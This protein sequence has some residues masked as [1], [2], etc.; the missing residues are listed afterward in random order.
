MS[1][2]DLRRQAP[3]KH[4]SVVF[5]ETREIYS[6]SFCNGEPS[7][8]PNPANLMEW[9]E[10]QAARL[11]GLPEVST[12]DQGIAPVFQASIAAPPRE[13]LAK[14]DPSLSLANAKLR[15]YDI[16]TLYALRKEAAR[17]N[18]ELKIHT[19]ALKGRQPTRLECFKLHPL[20]RLTIL[21]FSAYFDSCRTLV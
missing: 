3:F 15:V 17:K 9:V 8:G 2:L 19:A 13:S 21:L 5:F 12:A 6:M 4:P 7:T 11:P 10:Q 20:N 16:A 1:G 18:I 14:L